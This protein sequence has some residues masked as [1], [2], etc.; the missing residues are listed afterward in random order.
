MADLV[1]RDLHK[2]LGQA[3]VLR[4]VSMAAERGRIVAL[5]GPSGCGKTTVLRSLAGLERPERGRIEI[6]GQV[7]FDATDGTWVPPEK[8]G[9]GFVFQSY[10]LWPHRTVFENVAF[11]LRLRGAGKADIEARVGRTLQQLGLAHLRERYPDQLSGGQQQRVAICRAL[12]Y[13]PSVLLLDE[14]LSNLDA[15]LRE[16]ARFWIRQLILE[17]G[18][19]A[20]IVTHDQGEALSVADRVLLMRSGV[21][22]QDGS[23]GEL[24]EEPADLYVAEFLGTNVLFHGTL[25]ADGTIEGPDWR[26]PGTPREPLAP[27]QAVV[28]VLRAE[29]VGLS[30]EPGEGRLAAEVEACLYLGDHWEYRLAHHSLKLRAR[31]SAR[32]AQGSRL[33]LSLPRAHLWLFADPARKD[34]L[35][36]AA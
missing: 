24:Y 33:W 1:V 22:V 17:L 23:P 19:C 5:L 28:G 18:I 27:G 35:R 7:A 20:V 10:A 9:I 34:A 16:E 4:G 31:G 25:G 3:H 2:T 8:R 29:R 26:L 11:G 15:K 12:V 30:D 14:P 6:G 21:V 13:E 32:V 36:P